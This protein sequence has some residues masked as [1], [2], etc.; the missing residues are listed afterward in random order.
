MLALHHLIHHPDDVALEPRHLLR[1]QRRAQAEVQAL[2]LA[3]RI[4]HQGLDFIVGAGRTAQQ[5]QAGLLRDL[6]LDQAVFV[7]SVAQP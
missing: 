1:G 3:G 2:H 6:L 4:V 7:V 5:R